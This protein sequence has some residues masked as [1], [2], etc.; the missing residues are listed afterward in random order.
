MSITKVKWNIRLSLVIKL[1]YDYME[2]AA[3]LWTIQ[4]SKAFQVVHKYRCTLSSYWRLASK[5][6]FKTHL[7]T[8]VSIIWSQKFCMACDSSMR[9]LEFIALFQLYFLDMIGNHL[10]SFKV[11]KLCLCMNLLLFTRIC[12]YP[13]RLTA[14][15]KKVILDFLYVG[16]Q[17]PEI[18]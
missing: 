14:E 18:L 13:P 11:T 10:I 9:N 8:F 5:I 16:C 2:T 3:L 4:I 17:L 12:V 6:I 1:P 15:R 7:A